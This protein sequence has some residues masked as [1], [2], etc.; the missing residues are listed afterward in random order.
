MTSQSFNSSNYV[1]DIRP[2]KT[3]HN[4]SLLLDKLL[5][6]YNHHLRPDI[7]GFKLL[8]SFESWTFPNENKPNKKWY[9][10]STG[11]PTFVDVD[12][13]VRSMGPVSEADM[14][15]TKKFFFKYNNVIF[16]NN[17][18]RLDV[19][20][21]LLLPANVEGHA[22]GSSTSLKIGWPTLAKCVHVGSHLEARHLLLQWQKLV[23][24]HYH[25]AE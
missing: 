3:R 1:T 19:F 5:D 13:M 14:V 6:N 9:F 16:R 12:I 10:W 25:Y 24:A 22:I 4:V 17:C 2:T 21:R 11:P 23:P 8:Q 7:G 18:Q 15:K 20:A